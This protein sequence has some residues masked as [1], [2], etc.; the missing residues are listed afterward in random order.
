MA[1][2]ICVASPSSASRSSGAANPER[3]GHEVAADIVPHRQ[4]QHEHEVAGGS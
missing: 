1:S 3:A 2:E 4:R